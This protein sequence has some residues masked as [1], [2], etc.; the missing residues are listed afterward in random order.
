MILWNII[1]NFVPTANSN[2]K[3]ESKLIGNSRE[4]SIENIKKTSS[5]DRFYQ[6]SY[7]I[8]IFIEVAV[9]LIKPNLVA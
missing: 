8:D 6:T 5:F 3:C 4:I 7:F 1:D 9:S 2:K